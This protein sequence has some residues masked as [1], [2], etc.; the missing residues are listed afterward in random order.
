MWCSKPAPGRNVRTATEWATS[1]LVK[2]GWS[3]RQ[4][5]GRWELHTSNTVNS[6]TDTPI[7]WTCGSSGWSDTWFS[8]SAAMIHVSSNR[9]DFSSYRKYKQ[10][11]TIK[12]SSKNSVKGAGEGDIEVDIEC[13]GKTTRIRLTQSCMYLGKI[14]SLKVLAQKG[15]K[16]TFLQT[17]SASQ[18][19]TKPM[20]KLY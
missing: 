9:E 6:I 13:S 20:P 16:V 15:F 4:Y 17:T 5:P 2:R 18:R 3:R 11:C 8:N 14:L 1:K 12:V 10:E 7:V 19:I